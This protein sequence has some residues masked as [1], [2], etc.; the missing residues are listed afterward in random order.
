MSTGRKLTDTEVALVN[1][2]HSTLHTQLQRQTAEQ[3]LFLIRHIRADTQCP[4]A[5]RNRLLQLLEAEQ[6]YVLSVFDVTDRNALKQAQVQSVITIDDDL[7]AYLKQPVSQLPR[8]LRGFLDGS[9]DITKYK[10]IA[11]D[12]NPLTGKTR[13]GVAEF[14]NRKP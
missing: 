2:E 10:P 14:D 5:V 4:T 12:P 13:T 11:E 3:R 8:E 6:G 7:Y 9:I 1:Q